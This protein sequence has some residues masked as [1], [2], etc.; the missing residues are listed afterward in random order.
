MRN[1]HRSSLA[2]GLLAAS[3][4][5]AAAVTLDF[6]YLGGVAGATVT[7]T[8]IPSD[9][10]SNAVASIVYD[11]APGNYTNQSGTV[12]FVD[13]TK[14]Y[15]THSGISIPTGLA[16]VVTLYA[17]MAHTM[18]LTGS[19]SISHTT[20]LQNGAVGVEGQ[21]FADYQPVPEPTSLGA[22]ALG[23]AGLV[24]RRRRTAR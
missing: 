13:T 5:P 11:Y 10:S 21:F 19:G 6:H 17:D 8:A 2:L 16:G 12:T 22:V 3:V 24:S 15:F 14:V 20:V 9:S 7:S 4:A 1:L 23:L 18:P